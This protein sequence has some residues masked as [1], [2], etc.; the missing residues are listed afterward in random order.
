MK[1]LILCRFYFDQEHL[2]QHLTLETSLFEK[3]EKSGQTDHSTDR[4]DLPIKASHR[5]FKSI[6]TMNFHFLLK[7][8][9][10]SKFKLDKIHSIALIEIPPDQKNVKKLGHRMNV[11]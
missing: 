6:V 10:L 5:S 11:N 9:S 4:Q 2:I 1:G 7:S 8:L 3:L